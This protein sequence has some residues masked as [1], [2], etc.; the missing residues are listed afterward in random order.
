ME[1]TKASQRLLDTLN[2]YNAYI[3]NKRSFEHLRDICIQ[4]KVGDHKLRSFCW[5]VII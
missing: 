4:S 5:K 2:D 1:E 3:F